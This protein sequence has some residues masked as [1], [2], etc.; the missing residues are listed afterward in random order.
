MHMYRVPNINEV[1]AKR[2]AWAQIWQTLAIF[3]VEK[4]TPC[5]SVLGHWLC[6]AALISNCSINSINIFWGPCS[7]LP[8][9]HNSFEKPSYRIFFSGFNS[10]DILFCPLKLGNII[11]DSRVPIYFIPVKIF[12]LYR[13][14]KFIL[15]ITK[16]QNNYFCL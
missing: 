12:S 8:W 5:K 9:S 4:N 16:S 14:K 3:C 2:P 11:G 15:S 6:G 7:H 13:E 10:K 1:A